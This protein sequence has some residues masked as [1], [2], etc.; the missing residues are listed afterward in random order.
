MQ[1]EGTLADA[2][3]YTFERRLQYRYPFLRHN[4]RGSNLPD[5]TADGFYLEAKGHCYEYGGRIHWDQL[6]K[7]HGLVK[8]I[9]YMY[10]RHKVYGLSRMP[11]ALSFDTATKLRFDNLCLVDNALIEPFFAMEQR[12]S[13][14]RGENIDEHY[15]VFKP[16]HDRQ[17][18]GNDLIRRGDELVQAH[19]FYGINADEWDFSKVNDIQLLV[20]KEHRQL[21]EQLIS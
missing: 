17:I 5:F 13:K 14:K 16:R 18:I 8:P 2:I 1:R 20:L 10:G 7:F 21:I 12:F 6:E 11:K 19:E 4:E 15:C 9:F 3:G